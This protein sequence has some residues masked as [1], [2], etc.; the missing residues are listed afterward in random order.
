MDVTRTRCAGGI[1]RDDRGRLLLVRRGHA[2]D[3]GRWSLPGG[4][5]E[6]GETSQD[7]A[8]R[9]VLEE[10]GLRVVVTG[11]AGY[12]ELP[13]PGGGLYEVEDYYARVEPGTDPHTLRAGS[14]ADD[15]GWFPIHRVEE[16]DLTEGLAQTLREWGVLPRSG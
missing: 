9:E 1:V 4:R 6:D 5:V 3:E 12:V 15:V 11:V 7:A 10:T 2:P 14:D 16:L 13:A 8:V